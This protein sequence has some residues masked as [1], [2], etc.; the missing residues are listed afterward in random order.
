M[1]DKISANSFE[2]FSQIDMQQSQ[3]FE[4]STTI[5]GHTHGMGERENESAYPGPL[6]EATEAKSLSL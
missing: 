3:L 2:P 4:Y 5:G 6:G 1:D